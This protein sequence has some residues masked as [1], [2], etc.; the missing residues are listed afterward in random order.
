MVGG[1]AV[2]VTGDSR[3][4]VACSVLFLL[5]CLVFLIGPSLWLFGSAWWEGE[6]TRLP[7]PHPKDNE[8]LVALLW[9]TI[10]LVAGTTVLAVVLGVTVAYAIHHANGLRRRVLEAAFPIP[11]IL[12]PIIVAIG[13]THL[14][15]KR[16]LAAEAWS[17]LTGERFL[18][19]SIYG[20]F[21]SACVLA[22]CW[23]PLVTMPALVG[24][25]ALGPQLSV[26]GRIYGGP[27]QRF[28]RLGVPLLAPYVSAGAVFVAWLTLADFDVPSVFLRNAFPLEIYAAFQINPSIGLA[29]V[30]SLPLLGLSVLILLARTAAL[31]V[32]AKATLDHRWGTGNTRMPGASGNHLVPIAGAILLVAVGGPLVSLIHQVGSWATLHAGLQ[33]AGREVMNSFVTA[34]LA[35]CLLLMVGIPYARL[36]C[37]SRGW[38]RVALS[39]LALAPLALPGTLHGMAWIEILQGS[40]AGRALLASPVVISLAMTARFFPF[41]VFLLS[42]TFEG[43]H[44]G[45]FDAAK[46][47]GAGGLS[48]G[49]RV[50]LPLAYPGLLATFAIGFALSAGEL[51]SSIMINPVGFTTLP[52]RLSSLLHFGKDELLAGLCLAQVFLLIIPY[53]AVALLL[54]RALEVRLG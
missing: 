27:W 15:G 9:S 16:G 17:W 52:I 21:G 47:S 46:V 23:F 19:F 43:M 28:C 40:S 42:A 29:L 24:L 2:K 51:S 3:L 7:P 30:R 31:S 11:L 18:P 12:P 45:L 14:L 34:L 8:R 53:L 35:G 37:G 5:A 44:R 50:G 1:T 32:E 36:L 6:F 26:A 33:T 49:L 22:S 38:S 4:R 13:W 20:E 48:I 54:E 41:A 39:L 25:R 10:R